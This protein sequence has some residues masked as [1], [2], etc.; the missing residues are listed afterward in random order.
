MVP[1]PLFRSQ[2]HVTMADVDAAQILF[3]AAPLMWAERMM[4]AW[5]RE[6]GFP[7]SRMLA[8]SRGSPVV[9]TEVLYHRPLRLDDE[10]AGALW[11]KGRSRRSF[12]LLSCFTAGADGPLAVEVSVTQVSVEADADGALVPT[13]L[14][15]EFAAQL[16]SPRPAAET[17]TA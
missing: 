17:E 7:L 13:E 14:C 6:S 8:E 1:A 12:T 11:L 10:V 3:Y 4:T 16:G 2:F 9:R 15:D 5:R